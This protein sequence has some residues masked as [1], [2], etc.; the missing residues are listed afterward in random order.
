MAFIKWI[1]SFF[2]IPTAWKEAE[3]E[4]IPPMPSTD[5]DPI[6]PVE[7]IKQPVAETLLW[8]TPKRAWHSSRVVMDEMGLTGKTMAI[9]GVLVPLKDVLCACIYQ[10]SR[11]KIGA[12]G[13]KNYDGTQ[14]YGLC[15]YNNGSLK[16][17]PLWIGKGATFKDVDE[18][19]TSPEKN[20]RV[21]V[22]TWLAGHP[23]WW[24]SF[25]FN[26]FKQWLPKTSAMWL[27]RS[28]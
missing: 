12:I 25:K 20:V 11:F 7:V 22:K 27:L 21:M 9:D 18:V 15:Q 16:G 24:A 28:E 13:P 4:Y 10:E 17:I 26:A 6:V 5:N 19:L 2:K 8:D 1:L 3:M 14:D 23:S